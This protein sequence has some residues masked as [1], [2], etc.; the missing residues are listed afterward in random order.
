MEYVLYREVK[1]A[2]SDYINNCRPESEVKE[3]FLC[4]HVPYT[5]LSTSGINSIVNR[6]FKRSDVNIA[7]KHHG[8]HALR[9]SNS[10]L[11]VN[12]GMTYAETKQSIGWKDPSVMRHYV[13]ID[14]EKLR[15]CALEPVSVG[16]D[17]FFERFLQG[18]ERL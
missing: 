6:A 7:G 5:R 16:K 2:L 14:I 18:K 8:P 9:S 1:E 17:T 13:R 11:K 3:I 10:S 12:G 4:A 15:L